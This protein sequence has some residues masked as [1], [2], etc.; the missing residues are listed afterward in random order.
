MYV[1]EKPLFEKEERRRINLTPLLMFKFP[2]KSNGGTPVI[3][4]T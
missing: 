3:L 4:H 2:H 1:K